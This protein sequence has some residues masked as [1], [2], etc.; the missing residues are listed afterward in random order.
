MPFTEFDR[1]SENPVRM[2]PRMS[3][4]GQEHPMAS[5]VIIDGPARGQRFDL[6]EHTVIIGRDA[7]CAIRI[8]DDRV[9]R[10]HLQVGYDNRG[11]RHFALDVGSENGVTVNGIR[12]QRGSLQSLD[13]GDEIRIGRSS[14]RYVQHGTPPSVGKDV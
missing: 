12:L 6:R 1:I 14:L 8:P 11:D 10:R 7:S 9:L 5:L 2:R 4:T 3:L 13:S